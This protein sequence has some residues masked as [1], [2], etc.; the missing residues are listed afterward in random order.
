MSKQ[1]VYAGKNLEE[2]EGCTNDTDKAPSPE[3]G[4]VKEV[5]GIIGTSLGNLFIN[6]LRPGKN[7][8]ISI[9]VLVVGE[10]FKDHR[11]LVKSREVRLKIRLA[12]K[13]VDLPRVHWQKGL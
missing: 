5:R 11:G 1:I 2:G 8:D 13:F 12:T 9:P 7:L 4:L 3:F 10:K 6:I